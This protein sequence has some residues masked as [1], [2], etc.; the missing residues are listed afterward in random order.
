MSENNNALKKIKTEKMIQ[1][2][3]GTVK[4]D[5][6]LNEQLISKENWLR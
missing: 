4:G 3:D 6:N 2:V 1:R 5:N